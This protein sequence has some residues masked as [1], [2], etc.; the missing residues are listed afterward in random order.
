MPDTSSRAEIHADLKR[1][2]LDHAP[3]RA[4]KLAIAFLLL[5]GP[6]SILLLDWLNPLWPALEL[7]ALRKVQMLVAMLL[8]FFVSI[9][10]NIHLIK[11]LRALG[12]FIDDTI[13]DLVEKYSKK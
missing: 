10:L 13:P 12:R 8:T 1:L 5:S 9:Y 4:S 7:P 2:L 6:A 3:T 11:K